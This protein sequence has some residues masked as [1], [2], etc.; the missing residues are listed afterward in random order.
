MKSGRRAFLGRAAGL[1]LTA[2]L[3]SACGAKASPT[4]FPKASLKPYTTAPNPAPAVVYPPFV[5]A[6]VRDAYEFAFARPDVL[7]YLPCYCG[8]GLNGGHAS[9]LDCFVAGVRPD[10]SVQFDDHGSGCLI[11]DEIARD[12]KRLVAGGKSL[13]DI[14]AYV[15]KTHGTKGPATNTPQPP[16]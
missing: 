15:D 14:R 9:N 10:G 5:T 1:T 2:L 8:C 7:R 6:D 3:A 16:A 4:Q 12:A 11:C 13:R